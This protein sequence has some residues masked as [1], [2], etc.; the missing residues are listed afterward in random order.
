VTH[1]V[2]RDTGQADL[3]HQASDRNTGGFLGR[4]F[5]ILALPEYEAPAMCSLEQCNPEFRGNGNLF[6][7]SALAPNLDPGWADVLSA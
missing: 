4:R 7:L 1:C 5:T 6:D 2:M 3:S